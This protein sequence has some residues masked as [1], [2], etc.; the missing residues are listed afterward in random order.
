MEKKPWRKP[1]SGRWIV[2]TVCV[3]VRVFTT[4]V[5]VCVCG[6]CCSLLCVCV[7]VC[8][9]VWCV[10]VCVCVKCR[11]Q[12]LSMGLGHTSF[13]LF[14]TLVTQTYC[15]KQNLLIY[16]QLCI[17]NALMFLSSLNLHE[18]S[19]RNQTHQMYVHRTII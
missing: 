13:S 16:Q 8:V 18:V 12:I 1:G 3:C 4:C 7:C 9:C 6:V 19:E 10:C 2:F 15:F 5:C 14:F 17:N 11:A